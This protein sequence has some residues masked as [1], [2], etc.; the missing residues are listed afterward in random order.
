[1]EASKG[2]MKVQTAKMNGNEG[3]KGVAIFW[4]NLLTR[5]YHFAEARVANL[6]QAGFLT[7]MKGNEGPQG[8]NERK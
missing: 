8:Q 2:K 6:D 1:M 5:S 3:P 4:L 7:K